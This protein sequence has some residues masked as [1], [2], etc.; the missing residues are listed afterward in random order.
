[1][2][3]VSLIKYLYLK[4]Y[5]QKVIQIITGYAQSTISKNVNSS[6]P[7]IPSMDTI[8]KEQA[9]RKEVVDKILECKEISTVEFCDQD[10]AYIKL[11]D[12]LLVDREKIRKLYYNISQYKISQVL[13]SNKY[14]KEDF[15]PAFL[16]IS[17]EDFKLF[18]DKANF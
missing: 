15:N 9:I 10:R 17:E 2:I 11:L 1:M 4:G 5:R 14:K 3:N 18:L 12:Y 8:N 16:G 13:H 7:Y 6:R